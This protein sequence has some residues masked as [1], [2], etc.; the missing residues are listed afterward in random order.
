MTG[1]AFTK[2]PKALQFDYKVVT[3]GRSRRI[4]GMS[5]NG[6]DANRTDKA[7]VQILLQ[8]RWEDKDGN[9]YAKRIGTGWQLMEKTVN[10]WQNK[11][12]LAVNYGDI[13]KQSY[14]TA[15][16]RLR[17]G[18]EAYYTRNSK[19]KMVPIQEQGWGTKDDQVTH[20]IVQFSS[21]NGG[22]YIGSPE[23][24]L[25]VDNVGLVY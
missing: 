3:G 19:G 2:K 16:M 25:W 21:S 9:V 24:R 8:K 5:A 6:S 14:Y 22:A 12:R 13:S 23:S 7:E 15:D 1:I 10:S 11:H 17:K 20:L 18:E 4:N